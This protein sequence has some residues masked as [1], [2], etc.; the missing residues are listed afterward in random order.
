M[1]KQRIERNF[2][3]YAKYY[4][5]YSSVQ[6]LC[7]F[8]LIEGIKDKRFLRILEIG[9]GTG[10]YTRLLRERFPSAQI[11]ALDISGEMIRIAK[12][13]L[14]DKKIEFIVADGEGISLKERFDFITS[15]A[16]FQW[17]LNLKD[18]LLGYRDLLTEQGSLAFSI[19][20]PFTFTELNLCI[21]EI[22]AQDLSIASGN[23]VCREVIDSIL[24]EGFE[25]VRI[26]EERLKEEYSC[27]WELLLK[28]RYTGVGGEGVKKGLWTYN[29]IRKLERM[30]KERYKRVVATYQVF[31]CQARKGLETRLKKAKPFSKKLSGER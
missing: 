17:F 8:K 19:F 18:A 21:R 9:C 20:G 23:F 26:K 5:R 1:D 27:L 15:N 22:F 31:F 29:L 14:V 28:I 4:D 12:R 2:S 7:A 10:N 25:G 30:Y 3:R 24:R 13:K 16:S 11:T 6:E